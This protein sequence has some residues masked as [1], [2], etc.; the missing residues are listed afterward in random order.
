LLSAISTND[1]D[2][3]NRQIKF[4][5]KLGF[6]W[7]NNLF[8]VNWARKINNRH[9]GNFMLGMTRATYRVPFEIGSSIQSDTSFSSFSIKTENSNAIT[10]V[11]GKANLEYRLKTNAHL[12]Y[13]GE[14]VLHSFNPS[15]LYIAFNGSGS[16]G[17][18]TTFGLDNRSVS[19]EVS[20]YGEY[21]N[22]LGG[23]LKVNLGGRIW[24]FFGNGKTWI[25][26]EPRILI[27]Q[28]L[29][30]Q[31]ALKLGFSIANQG[32]HRLSSVNANLPG[33]IWF[34]TGGNIRPQQTLQITGGFYQPW[35]KGL[36]F[37]MEMYLKS[38]DGIT[39]LTGQ[40]ENDYEPRYW[41]RMLAQGTGRAY[42]IEFLLMT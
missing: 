29:Q 24:S 18:D 5:L 3:L 21:E 28:I 8:G 39:D 9:Y 30:G 11:I 23:G 17:F 37:S 16:T 4:N 1:V 12:R 22:N 41:E 27:S 26:P 33:D 2:S 14:W 6:N 19:P 35:K 31:K 25:R 7:Q 40:D 13:G 10:N 34:P 36:E 15:T 32:V 20:V 38:F 42:G